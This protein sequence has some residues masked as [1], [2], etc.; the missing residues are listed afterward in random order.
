[1]TV[2]VPRGGETEKAMNVALNKVHGD[3][4]PAK[5]AALLSEIQAGAEDLFHMTGFTE[6]S[7]NEL[8]AGLED[9]TDDDWQ[10]AMDKVPQGDREP[11]QTKTFTLSD[12]QVVVID[13]AISIA[14]KQGPYR[15]TGNENR[16]GNALA[17]ICA[18]FIEAN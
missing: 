16:N 9:A 1:M 17:R 11:Y 2:T 14:A 4:V 8:V 7:F 13:S 6:E 15:E 12:D 10:S 5:L 3:W 18:F